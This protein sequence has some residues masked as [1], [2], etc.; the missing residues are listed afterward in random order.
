MPLEV[1]GLVKR[2][3]GVTALAGVDLKV[4]ECEILGLIGPNGSGKTTLMNCISGVHQFDEGQVL[5]HG[6]DL[7]RRRDKFRA[8]RGVGRTFQNLKLFTELTVWENVHIGAN[9]SGKRSSAPLSDWIDLLNLNP[10]IDSVVKS[11]PY[12][13]QRR[14]E[15]ARALAGSPKVLLLDEPAAGLNDDETAEF[16]ELVLKI[17]ESLGCAIIMIDHD[18]NLVT[19]VSDRIQVLDEGRTL[20]EGDPK[21]AFAEQAVVDA[22]LGES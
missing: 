7:S 18:M 6:E 4:S 3:A 16:R 8:R 17:R 15:L 19:G 22:Y 9:A 1:R 11:L 10:V 13:Y 12:G 5:L 20:F 2:F 21:A 14:V